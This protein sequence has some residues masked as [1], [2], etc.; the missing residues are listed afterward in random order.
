MTSTELSDALRKGVPS[1]CVAADTLAPCTDR[2]YEWRLG[3]GMSE[4]HSDALQ[5]RPLQKN[6]ECA[7]HGPETPK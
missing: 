7:A 4:C 6:Q 1:H 5:D 3:E 2:L